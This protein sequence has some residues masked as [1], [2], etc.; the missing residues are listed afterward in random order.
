MSVCV[1]QHVHNVFHISR[2]LWSLSFH[3]FSKFNT[4]DT[5]IGILCGLAWDDGTTLRDRI[6][7]AADVDTCGNAEYLHLLAN[8]CRCQFI[9]YD[10]IEN[11][12]IKFQRDRKGWGVL[13]NTFVWFHRPIP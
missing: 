13:R 1:S 6:L 11:K 12:H 2:T 7:R 8:T 9:L 10:V 5:C 3:T 4:L